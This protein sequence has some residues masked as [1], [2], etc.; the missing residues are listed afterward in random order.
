MH[1]YYL[2]PILTVE[3][4]IIINS[5]M[6]RDQKK[7]RYTRRGLNFTDWVVIFNLILQETSYSSMIFGMIFD[8]IN[9]HTSPLT[10][11]P[12]QVHAFDIAEHV[13]RH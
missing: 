11:R 4:F 7:I 5:I 1:F 10:L 13:Y 9:P 2:R 3:A 6:F 12:V 8:L